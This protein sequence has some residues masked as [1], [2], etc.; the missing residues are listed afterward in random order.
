MKSMPLYYTEYL[1]RRVSPSLS[2]FDSGNRVDTFNCRPYDYPNYRAKHID[3]HVAYRGTT[4]C[5]LSCTYLLR[6]VV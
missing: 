5:L 1:R 2:L 6:H 3:V 4:V